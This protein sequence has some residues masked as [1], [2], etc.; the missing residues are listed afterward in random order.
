VACQVKQIMVEITN[1][2]VDE[3]ILLI[4]QQYGYDFANYSRASFKRRLQKL[5]ETSPLKTVASLKQ[6][7]LSNP[8]FERQLLECLT[9]NVTEMFRD[10]LFYKHLSHKILPVLASYPSIKIWHAGCSTGEEVFSL[11]ILL[12]EAG[13]LKRSRIYATDVNPANIEKATQGI[14]DA[15]MMKDYTQNY[16]K[17]GGRADFSSYYTARYDHAI[18]RKDIREKIVFFQ[19]NLCSDAAF[20]EFQLICC[21]NVLIYFD[22]VLQ[23]RVLNLFNASLSPLGYLALGTKES[24]LFTNVKDRFETTDSTAKVYRKKE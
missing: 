8:G 9:V 24:L 23:N 4:K 2:E 20:N 6:T 21:R 5:L 15:R 16:I 18:I 3:I 22:R 11:S 7:I 1:R 17:A 10:P 19:H 13:L 12:H 14:I